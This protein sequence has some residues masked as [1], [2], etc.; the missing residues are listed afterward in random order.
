VY[1]LITLLNQRKKLRW[2]VASKPYPLAFLEQSAIGVDNHKVS[3]QRHAL[4]I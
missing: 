2:G 4:E 1:L 3:E